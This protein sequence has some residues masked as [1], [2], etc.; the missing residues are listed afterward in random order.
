M[1][2]VC[3][4]FLAFLLLPAVSGCT[5][6]HN[7]NAV[8]ANTLRVWDS[9]KPEYAK[10]FLC[11]VDGL[12]ETAVLPVTIY[13][14]AI[15]DPDRG[16]GEAV[17][18]VD[19]KG[20]GPERNPS[21]GEGLSDAVHDQSEGRAYWTYAGFRALEPRDHVLMSAGLVAFTFDT[22]LLPA[23]LLVDVIRIAIGD[24]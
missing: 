22:V 8:Y 1:P 2:R 10:V 23:T 20:P 13:V 5:L 12:L 14:D 18:L 11:S 7:G 9:D 17:Q 21:V 19:R 4:V 16:D 24:E 3:L 15:R 6:T